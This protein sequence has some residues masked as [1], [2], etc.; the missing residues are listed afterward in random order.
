VTGGPGVPVVFLVQYT[1][2]MPC[3]KCMVRIFAKGYGYRYLCH[4]VHQG[5]KGIVHRSTMLVTG[6]IDFRVWLRTDQPSMH[7]THNSSRPINDVAGFPRFRPNFTPLARPSDPFPAVSLP[8]RLRLG[9]LRLRPR[10]Y[11]RWNPPRCA[12]LGASLGM[13]RI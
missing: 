2:P 5:T 8:K 12:E 7:V 1:W 4:Q 13:F 9:V 3:R 10:L 11:F 6:L